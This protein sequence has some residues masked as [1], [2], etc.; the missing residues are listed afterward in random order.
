MGKKRKHKHYE[1]INSLPP[2]IL[3]QCEQI[4]REI[5]LERT[6]VRENKILAARMRISSGYYNSEDV[7]RIIASRL[8][9]EGDIT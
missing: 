3:S 7:I 8:L 1:R 6:S 5:S 9:A 4:A 2:D